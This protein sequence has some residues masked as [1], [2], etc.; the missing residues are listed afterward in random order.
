MMMML[1]RLGEKDL[2]Q[3]QSLKIIHFALMSFPASFAQAAK[4]WLLP[5]KLKWK[6]K[7]GIS[8]VYVE[9]ASGKQ[10]GHELPFGT[11][12]ANNQMA[13]GLLSAMNATLTMLHQ[14]DLSLHAC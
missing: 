11:K 9:R 4:E 2:G 5:L 7:K 12:G 10:I 14:L 8:A 6:S 13:T 1:M 3:C